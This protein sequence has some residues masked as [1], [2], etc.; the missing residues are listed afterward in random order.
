M[1]GDASPELLIDPVLGWRGWSIAG[2]LH[3]E[4]LVFASPQQGDLWHQ[5]RLSWN[6]SCKCDISQDPDQYKRIKSMI[7]EIESSPKYVEMRSQGR[8]HAYLYILY[9]LKKLTPADCHCGINAFA[10]SAHLQQAMLTLGSIEAVGQVALTGTVRCFEKGWR[11]EH[12]QIVRV[13]AID[14][15]DPGDV[16]AAAEAAGAQFMGVWDEEADHAR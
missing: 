9:A 13:W 5:G 16:A 14:R 12:G 1:L 7:A 2:H 11:A 3:D 8:R 15:T 10:S 6:G 4:S